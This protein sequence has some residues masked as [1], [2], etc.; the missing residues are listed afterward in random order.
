M[1]L[2]SRASGLLRWQ[3]GRRRGRASI[4]LSGVTLHSLLGLWHPLTLLTFCSASSSCS[5]A[6]SRPAQCPVAQEVA[7]ASGPPPPSHLSVQERGGRC[8]D[9]RGCRGVRALSEPAAPPPPTRDALGIAAHPGLVLS[10]CL[11][12][13]QWH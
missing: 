6:P 12:F 4:T 2:L 3:S 5:Q 9:G 11:L 1:R 13:S 10:D 8:G 7:S